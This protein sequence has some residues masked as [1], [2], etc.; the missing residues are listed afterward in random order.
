[1]KIWSSLV[2]LLISISALASDTIEI[3]SPRTLRAGEYHRFQV[4][5]HGARGSVDV[6]N[7]SYF[8]GVNWI[9]R[10]FGEFL[11]HPANYGT[12]SVNVLNASYKIPGGEILNDSITLNIDSTPYYVNI[13]G[14]FLVYRNSGAQFQAFAQYRDMRK[15]ITTECQWTSFYGMITGYGYYRTPFNGGMMN[16]TVSCRY[17]S[18]A[19]MFSISIQ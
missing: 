3:I 6:T 17:G 1:M 7:Q 19:Q 15:D 10:G 9:R 18:I 13:L 5:Y 14:P 12:Q 4:I 8:S 2:L 11:V 16:D